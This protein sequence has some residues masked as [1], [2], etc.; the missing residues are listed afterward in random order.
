MG[1]AVR[2]VN[3]FAEATLECPYPFYDG[4]REQAPVFEAA[5]GVFFI[6]THELVSQV[7]RDTENFSSQNRAA[8][9]NFQGEEGLA[10]PTATPPPHLAEILKDDVPYR[11]TLLSADPPQHSHYRILVNRSMAPKRVARYE[12]II[13]QV[14][15]EL[16]DGFIDRGE[17]EFVSEFSM[18]LPLNAVAIALG[19]PLEDIPRYKDWSVRSVAPLA[20]RLT[21]EE[22]IDSTRAGVELNRYLAERTEEAR[23]HPGDNI[24]GDLVNAHMLEAEEGDEKHYRPLDTPEIVSILRQLLVAGQETVNYLTASLMKSLIE[25]PEKLEALRHAPEKIRALVEE[26]VRLESPIQR[27]GRFTK[28]DVVLGGVTIPA[29]SRVVIMYGCANRDRQKFSNP[30]ELNVDREDLRDHVGFGAGPHYCAGAPLARLETRIA[31]EE[32]FRRMK[33]FRFAPGRNT[34]KHQYSFIFRGLEELHIQFDKAE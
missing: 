8:F 10:P 3:P 4:L 24:I 25:Q 2:D 9:L 6:S 13:R 18:L 34:F 1:L 19:I 12:P 20:R 33:N 23:K 14:V 5:P 15:T 26:G 28:N 30:D 29:G 32:L 22:H 16:I 21:R 27:L 7:L 17:A 11:D 31:F